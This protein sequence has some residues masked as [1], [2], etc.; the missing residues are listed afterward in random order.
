[1]FTC[2]PIKSDVSASGDLGYTY[3][4]Y[5]MKGRTPD[6]QSVE[7]GYYVRMWKRNKAGKWQIVLD[8]TTALPAESGG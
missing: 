6:P 3:G 8:V 2:D 4:K 1:M 7:K 5:E